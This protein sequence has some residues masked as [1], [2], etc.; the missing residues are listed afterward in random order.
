MPSM[1]RLSEAFR[2]KGLQVVSVA[3]ESSD[4]PVREYAAKNNIA[5]TI[6]LDKE[7]D[8]FSGEYSAPGSSRNLLD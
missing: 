7:K 6:L 4:M 5:Y 1:N 3:I 8:V 2:E